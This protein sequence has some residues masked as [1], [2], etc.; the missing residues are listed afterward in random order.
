MFASR[1]VGRAW[2]QRGWCAG[3]GCAP[4]VRAALEEIDR[5]DAQLAMSEED[6]VQLY[7]AGCIKRMAHG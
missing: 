2:C 7:A 6:V 4:H 5:V 3:G 1:R